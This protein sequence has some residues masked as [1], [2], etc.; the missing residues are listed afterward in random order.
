MEVL[1]SPL[2]M[3][4]EVDEGAIESVHACAF[5][6]AHSRG[7]DRY[8]IEHRLDIVG[9][10][11]DQAQDLADSHP[12]FL[13]LRLVPPLLCQLLL[14][15]ADPRVFGLGRLADSRGL[16]FCSLRGLRTPTHWPPSA[17]YSG[18]T[19]RQARRTRPLGQVRRSN[20]NS[21]RTQ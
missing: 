2:V 8:G 7:S 11:R 20:A 18:T 13:R 3:S 10:A 9:R 1:G 16:G 15:V 12:L 5:D 17:T 14:K 4:C 6:G 19:P 21:R